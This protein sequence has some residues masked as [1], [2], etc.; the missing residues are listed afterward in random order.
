VNVSRFSRYDLYVHLGV[1][2][3]FLVPM[4]TCVENIPEH[5]RLYMSLTGHT[6]KGFGTLKS[7]P[8]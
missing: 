2:M 1:S 4:P 7:L 8:I 6:L 5:S 3:S